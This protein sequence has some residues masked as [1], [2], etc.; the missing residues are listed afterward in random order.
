MRENLENALRP[1]LQS[2]G[3]VGARGPANKHI[4]LGIL[5]AILVLIFVFIGFINMYEFIFTGTCSLCG[6]KHE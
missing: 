1:L 5:V 4:L 2:M 6:K 3:L